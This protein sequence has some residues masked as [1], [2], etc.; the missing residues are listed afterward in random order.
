MLSA[1][2]WITQNKTYLKCTHEKKP[3]Q[4]FLLWTLV[5]LTYLSHPINTVPF[6]NWLLQT[7]QWT[8]QP[9][10]NSI[11]PPPRLPPPRFVNEAARP[12]VLLERWTDHYDRLWGH[13]VFSWW[14]TW[15]DHAALW[16]QASML[17]FLWA[18][19]VVDDAPT[20]HFDVKW[21]KS[22]TQ[23]QLVGVVWYISVVSVRWSIGF[24]RILI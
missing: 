3:S 22:S 21:I 7:G 17:L 16:S 4:V 19:A 10:A 23:W 18:V 5:G 9:R 2:S 1:S 12:D 6:Y 15:A 13:V 20:N 11:F 8:R 24:L 14:I